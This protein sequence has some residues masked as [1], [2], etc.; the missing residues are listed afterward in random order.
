MRLRLTKYTGDMWF[1]LGEQFANDEGFVA[2]R[3]CFSELPDSERWTFNAAVNELKKGSGIALVFNQIQSATVSGFECWT[4][5]EA[6]VLALAE[7]V[8]EELGLDLH[9]D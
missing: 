2:W 3:P 9:I 5:D 7:A 8:A 6:K 4:D 1:I